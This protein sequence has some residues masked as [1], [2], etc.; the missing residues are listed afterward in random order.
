MS[1]SGIRAEHVGMEYE[2]LTSRDGLGDGTPVRRIVALTLLQQLLHR[3]YHCCSSCCT[4]LIT[5]KQ[6]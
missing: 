4:G 5:A 6:Y 1:A 3:S 2:G